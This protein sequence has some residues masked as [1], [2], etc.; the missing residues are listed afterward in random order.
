MK[1]ISLNQFVFCD[2]VNKAGPGF[3]QINC[4]HWE[5]K[6]GSNAY[7]CSQYCNL[8]N[9]NTNI[10]TCFSCQQREVLVELT[11]QNSNNPAQ[12]IKNHLPQFNFYNSK[13]Q[14]IGINDMAFKDKVKSYASAEG[15]QFL[16]GKVNQ[17]VFEK[18][19]AH[20]M[21]CHMR[22]NN[23]PEVDNIGWC[24]GC[25]CSQSNVRAGLSQKLW[26]PALQCPLNKFG[27]EHGDGFK[28]KDAKDA[29]DGVIKS[30]VDFIN[31]NK[32]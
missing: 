7:D 13:N 21:D 31:P 9:T 5:L 28:L 6:K 20:C 17:E 11:E 10:K 27:P 4:K 26:M 25:G 18:R 15:S 32:D 12:Q 30:V 8:K 1:N 16:N 2:D 14:Q 3:T 24:G 23:N 29:I 19:K 22:K